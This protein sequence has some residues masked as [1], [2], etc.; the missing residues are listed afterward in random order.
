[1]REITPS[2]AFVRFVSFASVAALM[3]SIAIPPVHA[4]SM[5]TRVASGLSS[6]IFVT[7]P[8]G[9]ASRLFIAEQGSG[10]SAN[11]KILNLATNVVSPTP[12]LTISGLATG[13]EQGLLG[14]AFDPGYASNGKFYVNV[15]APG[16]SFGMG[17]TQI[18]QYTVSA[19]PNIAATTFNTVFSLTQPQDNHNGG[20]IGFSPRPGDTNNLYISTGDGGNGNDQ[21]TGH[22]EPGGNA[23]NTSILLGKMLRLQINPATGIYT[24]PA[25]NPFGN[26]VFAFGLRNPFRA[27]FDRL[28][29]DMFIGDV[30][31]NT[32]EEV[33]RQFASNPNGGEN[34]G[35]RLRE[36]TIQT[37]AAGVGGARPTGNVEPILDYD[38][39]V[40]TTVTGGYVYRGNLAPSLSGKYIF[41]DFGAGKIFTAN[42]DGTGFQN[43]TSLFDPPGAQSIGNPSSF[44]EDA[45]GELYIVDY[46]DGEIF[47]VIP[48]PSITALLGAITAAGLWFCRRNR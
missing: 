22:F 17:I 34:Y 31:Q 33:D 42:P 4:Q 36:G 2:L 11:I 9:D 26:E 38:R 43:A 25:T 32:R 3:L 24:I 6:P 41:A 29:G 23:Q 37:P 45:T 19:N 10:G 47:R 13:G 5:T 40:G 16:G 18:R 28:T 21:G 46:A 30:G 39:A 14:L 1:M 20:W 48:E 35:W 8:P 12:F 15:T 7:A 27:S 44:G